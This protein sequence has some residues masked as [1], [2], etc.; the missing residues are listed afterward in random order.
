M[1]PFESEKLRSALGQ[2]L[3]KSVAWN[4]GAQSSMIDGGSDLEWVSG[5]NILVGN[6]ATPT[7][8]HIEI[9]RILSRLR[10]PESSK[11]VVPLSYGDVHYREK[12]VELGIEFL[13]INSSQSWNL[14][15][16]ISMFLCFRAV[17]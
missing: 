13:V 4:Y 17:L 7:N 14:W 9:F 1:L 6:S 5:E 16:L 10:L 11:I 15:I 8:N 2:F 12:I 3:P